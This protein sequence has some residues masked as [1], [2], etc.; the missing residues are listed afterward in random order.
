MMEK[1]PAQ[2]AIVHALLLWQKLEE[3]QFAAMPRELEEAVVHTVLA[4][5]YKKAT[6]DNL[7]LKYREVQRTT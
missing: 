3:N 5:G 6:I 4:L 1:T 2:L 7:V